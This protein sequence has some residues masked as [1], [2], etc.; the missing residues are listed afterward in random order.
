MAAFTV[1]T[2]I[3]NY[4]FVPAIGFNIGM[5]TFTAQN[6]GARKPERIRRGVRV[7]ALMSFGI[8]ALMEVLSNIFAVQISRLFGVES[9]ALVLAVRYVRFMSWFFFTFA[10]YMVFTGTLQGAGDVMFATLCSIIALGVRVGASYFLVRVIGT[11]CSAVWK[12][13]PMG[14]ACALVA[15]VI[16]YESGAWKKK[17]IV[18]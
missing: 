17:G 3:E 12:A 6:T 4:L 16:R 7:T 15:S 5:A 10:V 11:D 18:Q 13:M 14:W 1:G 9:Q 2:R 8:A